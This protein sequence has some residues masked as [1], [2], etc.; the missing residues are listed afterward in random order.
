MYAKNQNITIPYR[1][2]RYS[3]RTST[4]K[5]LSYK[6][7]TPLCELKLNLLFSPVHVHC[8]LK[9]PSIPTVTSNT[10]AY[11]LLPQTPQH[12]NCY[13]KH[14]SIPTVTSNTPAYQLLPQTPQRT[15]CYL[16]HPSVPTVTSNIPAYQLLPQTPQHTNCYLKHPS[17]PTTYTFY[18]L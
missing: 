4:I 16:K 17:I 10:P 18:A 2:V 7:Q 13:L 1:T 8:Y 12:T 3:N 15:N 6:E 14:P 9:H 11:Q 5:T